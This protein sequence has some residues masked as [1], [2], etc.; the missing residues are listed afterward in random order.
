MAAYIILFECP[1][2]QMVVKILK[3]IIYTQK[4]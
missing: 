3:Q 1:P 4:H 2:G